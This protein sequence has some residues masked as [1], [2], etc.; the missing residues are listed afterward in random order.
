MGVNTLLK[1]LAPCLEDSHVERF[2]GKTVAVDGNTFIF[3][4]CYSCS[5]QVRGGDAKCVV[6]ANSKISF[7]CASFRSS[8]FA[9]QNNGNA[10]LYLAWRH[11]IKVM[12]ACDLH[13][14][15]ACLTQ[16]ESTFAFCAAPPAAWR[17]YHLG[18][19]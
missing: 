7:G 16:R 8:A 4:G 12:A 11:C 14:S 13:L 5:E 6:V 17:V 19:R 1:Q 9:P 2:R 15:A 10:Y 3:R 18:Y